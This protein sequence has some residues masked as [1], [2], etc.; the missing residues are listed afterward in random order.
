MVILLV[1]LKIKM[2]NIISGTLDYENVEHYSLTVEVTDGLYTSTVY[3]GVS[4]TPVN[5][6]APVFSPPYT[7]DLPEDAPIGTSVKRVTATDVDAPTHMHG[8]LYYSIESG[9]IGGKFQIDPVSG[10]VKTV[11]SLDREMQDTYDLTIQATEEAGTNSAATNLKISII[12]IDDNPPTCI[13]NIISASVNE[14]VVVPYTI[15]TLDCSDVDN[16]ST[17]TYS[18][19]SGDPLT[20]SMNGPELQVIGTLDWD[21]GIHDYDVTVSVGDGHQ[22]LDISGKITVKPVNEFPPVFTNGGI[23]ISRY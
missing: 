23:N 8:K 16:S 22:N 4:V 19:K 9:N 1:V 21:A 5:E 12:D 10:V 15:T 11:G 2:T 14:D 17:L 13:N 7:E 3:I 18:L 6:G 20:F